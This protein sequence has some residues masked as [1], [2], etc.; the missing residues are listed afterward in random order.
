MCDLIAFHLFPRVFILL[1]KI[2][3]FY[4]KCFGLLQDENYFYS[5]KLK[6]FAD[7][8]SKFAKI[9]V[10]ACKDEESIVESKR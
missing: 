5:T 6:L 9:N 1:I 8:K 3:C 10:F 4:Y 2:V 7:N